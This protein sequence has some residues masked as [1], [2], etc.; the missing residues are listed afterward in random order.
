MLAALASAAALLAGAG[1]AFADGAQLPGFPSLASNPNP[2]T[3]DAR[4]DGSGR[5]DSHTDDSDA[6]SDGPSPDASTSGLPGTGL[7]SSLGL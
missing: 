1:V 3:A 6:D 5:N 2:V 7:L 4:G